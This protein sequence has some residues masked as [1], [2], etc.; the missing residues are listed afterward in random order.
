MKA[1]REISSAEYLD[2]E[3]AAATPFAGHTSMQAESLAAKD[4]L[5]QT[6]GSS[7]S[8]TQDRHLN[9][10]LSSLRSI[11]GRLKGDNTG[12]APAPSPAASTLE[13]ARLPTWDQMR[14]QMNA[15]LERAKRA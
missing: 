7:P 2:D 1:K 9:E 10:A 6:V 15:L 8:I 13:D 14:D 12:P 4:A 11:V 5:E 3:S